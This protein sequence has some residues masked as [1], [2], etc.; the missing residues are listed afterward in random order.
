MY[1]SVSMG[2]NIIIQQRIDNQL[3]ADLIDISISNDLFR[4][5]VQPASR[6]TLC[7]LTSV[8][9]HSAISSVALASGTFG[10]AGRHQSYL[11]TPEHC[12]GW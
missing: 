7:D 2:I 12:Q 5:D 6:R 3:I 11:M 9:A 10:I 1:V 4:V 8:K